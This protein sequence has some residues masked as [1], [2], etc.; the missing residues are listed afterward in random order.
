MRLQSDCVRFATSQLPSSIESGMSSYVASTERLILSG[1]FPEQAGF[2]EAWVAD[3]VHKWEPLT[4]NPG[5]QDAVHQLE[6]DP[7]VRGRIM[8]FDLDPAQLSSRANAFAA[9]SGPSCAIC[10][11][12]RLLTK[13]DYSRDV[14]W[15]GQKRQ[16]GNS[17]KDDS[18]TDLLTTGTR[19]N[20]DNIREVL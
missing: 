8:A 7:L 1:T 15:G 11:A 19:A 14:G 12:L 6:D 2:R 9:V 17:K 18:W 5:I 10:S 13:G 20:L 4:A 16:L 3:E